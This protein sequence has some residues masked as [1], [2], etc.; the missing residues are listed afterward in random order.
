MTRKSTLATLI[1]TSVLALAMVLSGSCGG[2]GDHKATEQKSPTRSVIILAIDGLRADS[3]G[4]YGGTAKTPALDTLASESVRFDQAW[5]QAP[6]MQAS[7][8]SLLT[9]LYPT[10]HGLVEGGDRLAPEANTLAE[11][12][13]TAGLVT[14]AFI[15]GPEGGD[16]FGLDQGFG[17]YVIGPKPGQSG[18]SWLDQHAEEDLFLVVAGW[19]AEPLESTDAEFGVKAPDGFAERLQEVLAADASDA[20]IFLNDAD[21]AYAQAAYTAHVTRIDT[22]IGRFIEALRSSGRLDSATLVVVGVSGFA[23]SEHGDLINDSLYP[24]VTR[25]PLMIRMP[26]GAATTIDTVVEVLD[27]MP[28]LIESAGANAPVGLQGASLMPI[29]DG[30]SNPPYIAFSESDQGDGMTSVVMNGMQLVTIG[31]QTSLFDLKADPMAL[32]DL[33]SKFPERAEVLSEHL[34][35]WSKMVAAASLDPERKTED[36]DDDTLDQ[37]RSLGYIQ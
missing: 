33:A 19:S 7:L 35:A 6:G 18:L 21:L 29:I 14:A 3:L 1:T 16:A 32:T 5:P 26:G 20:P 36:L 11:S 25:V 13:S 9:G 12:L 2:N 10:T 37:L 8:A 22:A 24:S 23:F 15:Q 28:T 31:G 30:T 34:Q 17:K 4:C 27:L